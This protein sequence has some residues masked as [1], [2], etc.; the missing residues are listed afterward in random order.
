MLFLT[1]CLRILS[2][3]PCL[4]SQSPGV[5]FTIRSSFR[6]RHLG[7]RRPGSSNYSKI[8]LPLPFKFRKWLWLKVP[9]IRGRRKRQ[10]LTFMS[11]QQAR[12]QKKNSLLGQYLTVQSKEQRHAN[13]S[14]KASSLSGS[15]FVPRPN[16]VCQQAT[17]TAAQ[18]PGNSSGSGG[19]LL[20]PRCDG[21]TTPS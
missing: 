6:R 17:Y 2:P 19:P 4:P 12:V 14:N 9:L 1:S 21:F 3:A 20:L 16:P 15:S 5:P 7:G 13:N 8:H 18:A 11:S 10:L